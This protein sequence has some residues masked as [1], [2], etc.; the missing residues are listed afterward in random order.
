MHILRGELQKTFSL[1]MT[2]SSSTGTGVP[3]GIQNQKDI[4]CQKH[5]NC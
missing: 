2:I 3:L 4:S 1:N 5:K